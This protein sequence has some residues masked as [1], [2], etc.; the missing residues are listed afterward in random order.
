MKA[1]RKKY[2]QSDI[3]RDGKS[4]RTRGFFQKGLSLTVVCLFLLAAMFLPLAPGLSQTAAELFDQGKNTFAS[5]DPQGAVSLFRRAVEKDPLFADAYK[6]LFFTL[7]KMNRHEDIVKI[8]TEAVKRAVELDINDRAYIYFRLAK[9]HLALEQFIEAQEAGKKARELDETRDDFKNLDQEIEQK[10]KEKAAAL[11]SK[12]KEL[13]DSQSF[14]QVVEVLGDA[15]RLDSSNSEMRDLYR[16]AQDEIR[17][18]KNKK[19]ASKLKA[20]ILA[21]MRGGDLDAA[22]AH[23]QSAIEAQPDNQDFTELRE[24]IQNQINQRTKDKEAARL[25]EEEE[26]KLANQLEYHRGLGLRQLDKENWE[27]AARSFEIVLKIAP[28]D[29]DIRKKMEMAKRGLSLQ[30]DIRK[31]KELLSEGKC[32]QAAASFRSALAQVPNSKSLCTLLAKCY[33]EQTRYDQAIQVYESFIKENP[34]AIEF[35]EKVG[36]LQMEDGKAQMAV[37]TYQK[38]LE[39]N[40]GRI[41]LVLKVADALAAAGKLSDAE[42]FMDRHIKKKPTDLKLLEKMAI[43][44]E[45]AKRYKEAIKTYK[46]ILATQ[47]EQDTTVNAFYKM[48]CIFMITEQYN[49]AIERFR[50]V[51]KRH[52]NYLDVPEKIKQLVWKKY[53][54]MIKTILILVGLVLLWVLWGFT[55]PL[56]DSLAEGKKGKN[57]QNAKNLLKKGKLEKGAALY[58]ETIKKFRLTQPEQKDAYYQ[59]AQAFLRGG[60]NDKALYYADKLTELERKNIKAY[61]ISAEAMLKMGNIEKSIMQCR[62]ALD[63]DPSSDAIHRI[64]QQ[65]YLSTG[66]VE[67]LLLEYEELGHSNPNNMTLRNIILKL[68]NEHGGQ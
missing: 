57:I 19:E 30:I 38:F 36:D 55:A 16:K 39:N 61:V 12:A 17:T 45:K 67:E 8:G 41:D 10:K 34:A 40:P 25:R 27:E 13:F 63:I 15:M 4:F 29:M 64:F 3:S 9:S 18:I 14:T 32:D 49:D 59:L 22:L 6:A 21:T 56:W 31:G 5:G 33:E 52:P 35:M 23:A 54:P 42:S 51:D 44:Q 1:N 60:K 28:N 37:E 47:P 2:T 50:E 46:A 11:F 24:Q 26:K 7:E 68:K 43:I 62:Y 20:T 53:F 48:G 65:A 66:K 58:E